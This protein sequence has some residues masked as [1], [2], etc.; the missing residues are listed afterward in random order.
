MAPGQVVLLENLRFHPGEEKNDPEFAA[1][2]GRLADFF[3]RTPLRWRIRAHAST[4]A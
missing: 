3:V 4:V 1:G 2:L